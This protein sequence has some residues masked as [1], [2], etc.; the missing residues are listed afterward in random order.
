MKK[1]LLRIVLSLFIFL[2]LDLL[3]GIFLIPDDFNSFRTKHYYY[4]HGLLPN[5]ETMA[6]WGAL[7]YPMHTNS[8]GLIDSTVYKLTKKS[9][10]HRV[11]I[12]GDSHSEG[13]G[14]PYLKSFAGR[15][16]RNL[17]PHGIEV[18]NGSAVSYSQKIEYLK[19]EYLIN[20]KE[21]EINEILLLVDMSDMQNELVY[22]A[23]E[24]RMRTGFGDFIF[25]LKIKLNKISTVNYLVNAIRTGKEQEQFFQSIESFYSDVRENANNNIWDLYSGFFSHFDDKVLLSNPEF[26]GM[27]GWLQD[28]NFKKLALQ[29]IG[30]GQRNI[31]RLKELCDQ[32]DIQLTISVHPWHHQIELANP[33]DEYVKY[34]E[35]F[36]AKY[37]I[38]FINFFPLFINDEAPEMVIKK[39]YIKNDNHWNE[40][41]HKKVA[42]YLED[43]F[44]IPQ[45]Q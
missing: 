24:P 26:H 37:E 32:H 3:S 14:V 34:W 8:L 15:L 17:K 5:Q 39:Y 19:A 9:N 18:I 33:E 16:S 20:E 7:V 1:T 44:I 27:A 21:L 29:G 23:Y 30:L 11:L 36:A 6:A 41:G 45:P 38:S 13:V 25:K 31:L 22:E 40:F 12:L 42:D 43:Y 28:E 2:G 4:H 35:A 10:F